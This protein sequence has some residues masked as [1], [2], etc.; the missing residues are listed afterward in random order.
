MLESLLL[1]DQINLVLENNDV[2]E[3][4]DFDSCQVFARLRL[5][6]C[7]VAGNEEESGIHNRGT[8]KHCSHQDVV[9]GTINE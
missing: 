6:T 1:L 7:F 8:V 9:T 2:L 4:H 3:L 5:G